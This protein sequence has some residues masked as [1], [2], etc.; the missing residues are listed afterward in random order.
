MTDCVAL[1]LL[2]SL[3]L[4]SHSATIVHEETADDVCNSS[5]T[6]QQLTAV[7]ERVSVL[8]SVLCEVAG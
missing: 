4:C 7:D 2:V 3:S 6:Q 5:F 1:P 8:Y